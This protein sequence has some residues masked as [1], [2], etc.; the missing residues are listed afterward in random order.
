MLDSRAIE[1]YV[2]HVLLPQHPVNIAFLKKNLCAWLVLNRLI[3]SNR[4]IQYTEYVY[5]D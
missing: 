5:V 2:W 3:F 1:G 4:L